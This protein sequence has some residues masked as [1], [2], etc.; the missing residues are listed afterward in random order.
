LGKEAF[1]VTDWVSGKV[2]KIARTGE[3]S[4]L[5]D[6]GQGTADLGYDAASKTAYIPQM[7]EGKLRA[8]K[9]SAE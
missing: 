1:L 4:E 7:K 9:I 3:K 5:M 2:Y 8:F 6:L